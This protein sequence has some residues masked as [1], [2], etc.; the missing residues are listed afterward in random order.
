M[1]FFFFFFLDAGYHLMEAGDLN[2]NA[3]AFKRKFGILSK[4]G[5]A[6]PSSKRASIAIG[7]SRYPTRGI[8]GLYATRTRIS[9]ASASG[10]QIRC[11]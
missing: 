2:P 11:S 10:E 8:H 1:F 7:D 6:K 3:F 5:K 4:A 9:F